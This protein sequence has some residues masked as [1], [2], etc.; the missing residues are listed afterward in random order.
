MTIAA[1]HP[2]LA[3]PAARWTGHG[4]VLDGRTD[5]VIEGY[6]RSANGFAV[7]AF[8]LTQPRPVRVAHHTHAPGHVIA[9]VRR[10]VPALVLARDPDDAVAE[11]VGVKPFLSARQALRA[12]VRFYEPLLPY[13]DRFVV[14]T[15]DQVNAD[16]GSVIHRVNERFGTR[17][18]EFQHTEESLRKAAEEIERSRR[19]RAGAGLPLVGRTESRPLSA[20]D[21]APGGVRQAYSAEILAELRTRARGLFLL[22]ESS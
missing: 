15:F 2:A 21:P 9:A 12:Y 20:A 3:L 22:M 8:S 18:R 14:G 4:V 1:E 13:R 6:P 17:F 7:A 19:G 16:F 10:G 11:W 5:I